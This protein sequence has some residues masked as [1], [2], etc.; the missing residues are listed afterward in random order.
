VKRRRASAAWFAPAP[1][2]RL[3]ALRVL[4]GG[5]ALFYLARRRRMLARIAET[6]ARLFAPVGLARP[7]SRPLNPAA[8]RATVD[9]TLLANLAFVAGA[10]HQV[11]GPLYAWLLLWTLSYR[12]SWSMIFHSDNLL[13]L[14]AIVLACSRSADALALDARRTRR[15]APAPHWRYGWPIQLMRTLTTLPYC[16]AGIAKVKGPLGWRWATGESLRRQVAVDG[17]RKELLGSSATPAAFALYRHVELFRALAV[18]S[19]AVELLAPATLAS[20]RASQLWALNA[21]GMHWGILAV[22]GIRFRYQLA[23]V[24]FAPFFPVERPLARAR[25]VVR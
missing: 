5:Y 9:A 8:A 23:G 4:I 20:R 22:M 2:E 7:L 15:A 10:W 13:A 18:G 3:G 14:H 19:L 21:L 25:E 16:L 17:L 24:A 11:T 12:N 1:A 6:D